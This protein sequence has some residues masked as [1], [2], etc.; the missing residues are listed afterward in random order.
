MNSAPIL[1]VTLI[2]D[3]INLYFDQIQKYVSLFAIHRLRVDDAHIADLL[4][5]DNKNVRRTALSHESQ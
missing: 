4:M 5:P 3:S 1:K 2:K